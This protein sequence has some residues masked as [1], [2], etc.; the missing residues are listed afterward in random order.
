MPSVPT[1]GRN[2]SGREE[3]NCT[4]T[5]PFQDLTPYFLRLNEIPCLQLPTGIHICPETYVF[6]AHL[7][8]SFCLKF[9]S[10]GNLYPDSHYVASSLTS[11]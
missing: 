6:V 8:V 10:Q 7:Q 9:L 2:Q 3:S 11:L 4:L 5:P 1:A